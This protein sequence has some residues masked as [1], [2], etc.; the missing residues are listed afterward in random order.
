MLRQIKHQKDGICENTRRH[1]RSSCAL[2]FLFY[3]MIAD[4]GVSDTP[5]LLLARSVM[6]CCLLFLDEG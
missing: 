6:D 3:G 1:H 2:V 4:R 5:G